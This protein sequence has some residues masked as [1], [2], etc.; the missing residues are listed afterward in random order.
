MTNVFDATPAEKEEYIIDMLQ[1]G[2]NYKT[3]MKEC[4]VSPSTI[5]NVRKAIA[6]NTHKDSLQTGLEFSKE[7]QALKLF[8]E[9]RQPLEVAVELDLATDYIFVIHERYQR[10]RGLEEF[11][12]AYEHVK[13]NIRPFL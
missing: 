12:R 5:S 9:G 8:K 6:G 11:T 2:Y 4:H 3:I 10:L 1:R 7:T 13:G